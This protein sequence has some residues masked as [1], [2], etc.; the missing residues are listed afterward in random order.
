M[1]DFINNRMEVKITMA[2]SILLTSMVVMAAVCLYGLQVAG[3][4]ER[5]FSKSKILSQIGA[6]GVSRVIEQGIE[7]GTFTESEVFE[8]E[9]QPIPGYTPPKYHT[10]YDAY[11]D[12]EIVKFQ[13]TFLKDA[14]IL[15]AVAMDTNGY[16]PTHNSR[17]QK[18]HTGEQRKDDLGDRAKRIFT[19]AVAVNAV[20][21]LA[22]VFVQPFQFNAGED[23]WD[24]SSPIFVNGKHWGAFSIGYRAEAVQQ[25][26]ASLIRMLLT[27][28]IFFLVISVTAVFWI[29][30]K[31]VR[32]LVE[33]TAKASHLA[34]GD[35]KQKISSHRKD[36]VGQIAD[37]LER[38]RISLKAAMDRLKK[39]T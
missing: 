2:V 21:S 38:L 37:A 32:P 10:R 19:D 13:D 15:Y 39:G 4:E 6:Q 7:K 33:L 25:Q 24:I 30:S 9:Y 35:I 8:T 5:F 18:A 20:Q 3:I 29:V 17:F 36:E 14:D 28:S 26:K 34:D 16:V 11:L 23:A 22:E 27:G 12:R 1:P 31:A